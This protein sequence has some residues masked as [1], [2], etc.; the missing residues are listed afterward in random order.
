MLTKIEQV[1]KRQL[2]EDSSDGMKGLVS[3]NINMLNEYKSTINI[4][5][6]DMLAASRAAAD[7]FRTNASTVKP[8]ITTNSDAQDESDR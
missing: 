3:N 8:E 5:K 1:I 4:K 7:I 2:F 6:I